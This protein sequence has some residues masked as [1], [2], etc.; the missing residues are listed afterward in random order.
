M[1][2]Q[3]TGKIGEDLSASYLQKQ[4]YRILARNYKARYGEIDIVAV[5]DAVLV[6]IEVKTRSDDSFGAPEEAV[7]PRK[8]REVVQT[9][10]YFKLAHADLPDAMRIDVIGIQLS[11]PK[12]TYFKHT[13]NVTM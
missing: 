7:T 1:S 4:G 11:G 6:F 12:V 10:E 3:S 2:N 5:K 8:L 13:Q 9:A